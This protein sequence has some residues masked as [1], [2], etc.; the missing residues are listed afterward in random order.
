MFTSRSYWL[1]HRG[2]HPPFLALK[3]L[4]CGTYGWVEFV[5]FRE[6][7]SVDEVQRFYERQ[8]AYLALLYV[9]E[10]TD[11]HFDNSIACGEH[12][13]LVDLETLFHPRTNSAPASLDPASI[14]LR[15]ARE[16]GLRK[17]HSSAVMHQAPETSASFR[18]PGRQ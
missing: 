1:N 9:L 17:P 2:N 15:T 8:G 11:V 6:C 3:I 7:Q 14:A 4:D 13:F 12:P 16:G 18:F 5:E 10:A